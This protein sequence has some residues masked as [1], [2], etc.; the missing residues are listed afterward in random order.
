MQQ[1]RRLL[2]FAVA[3][4]S[5]AVSAAQAAPAKVAGV[6][7]VKS[8]GGIDEYRLDSNGLAILLSPDDSM[9]TVT[10]NVV[11]RVGSRNE[12][13]G[14]TGATHLLE[15]LMFK[16]THTRTSAKGNDVKAY[17][18]G[19]GASFNAT[20][21]ND[22]TNYYAALR[23]EDLEEYVAIEAD[24]MRNLLLR[25][26]DLKAEMT[27][28]RN[29]FELG[30][31]S[32]A[33]VLDEEVTATAYQAL[34]YHHS[35]I[36]WKSDIEN[37]P[38]AKLRAFYDTF[39]WPDNATVV[40]AGDVKSDA[41]LQMIKKYFGEHPRAP[42]AIPTMYTEEPKQ[43][44]PRRVIVKRP[45]ELGNFQLAHKVPNARDADL[46]AIAMLSAILGDGK[47]SRLYR[48]LVD[49]GLAIEVGASTPDL[50]DLS[51]HS[52]YAKL[53][54][55]ATH[56]QVEA[57]V[58]AELEKIRTGG[59]TASELEQVKRKHLAREDYKRDGSWRIAG[60]LT[61]WI[62]SGDWTLFVTR[63]A[64]IAK[65]TPADVQRVA[66]AYFDEDNSTTG[67]LVRVQAGANAQLS[68]RNPQ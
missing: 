6:S 63:P 8:L 46:P 62:A 2:C 61:E 4:S 15:H 14:T 64:A 20:T 38:I 26:E 44:G 23:K 39:Y 3:L 30:K 27:V 55:G 25:E 13:T 29:E 7:Y 11:Y 65:V 1:K 66:K 12:V 16:G 60:E 22:R 42:N 51:L 52:I 34:P 9:P 5:L 10:F 33:G 17:L 32:P 67:W 68:L 35:T 50:H 53:A 48:A 40:L 59:V 19:V 45:G 28:V 43:S 47:T 54:P 21:S 56:A 37:V 58:L 57:V 41:A 18:D 49:A 24:R 36:G 31:N